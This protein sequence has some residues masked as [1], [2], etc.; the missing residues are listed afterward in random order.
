MNL[1]IIKYNMHNFVIKKILSKRDDL[2]ER[3]SFKN[4]ICYVILYCVLA[5]EAPKFEYMINSLLNGTPYRIFP[6]FGG[7]V[8]QSNIWWLL[9][10]SFFSCGYLIV[11]TLSNI[12]YDMKLKSDASSPSGL[13]PF[14]H[15]VF[16]FIISLNISTLG[17]FSQA[18]AFITNFALISSIV[19]CI[20]NEYH[21]ALMLI[22]GYP[23]YFSNLLFLFNSKWKILVKGIVISGMFFY[24]LGNS[25]KI[26]EKSK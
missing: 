13:W 3:F 19:T 22:V 26:K 15:S 6:Q 11:I 25:F 23:T 9:F 12:G 1:S 8:S 2:L 17:S 18:E 21:F 14:I 10:H 16:I 7:T 5:F 20:I 4:F 24:A